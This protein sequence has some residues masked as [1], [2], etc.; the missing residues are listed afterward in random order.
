M[1]LGVENFSRDL[2]PAI[3]NWDPSGDDINLYPTF[4]S[5]MFSSN[6]ADQVRPVM[7][8]GHGDAPVD[9]VPMGRIVLVEADFTRLTLLQLAKV[10][11]GSSGDS[12]TLLVPN[13]AGCAVYDLAKQI[14]IKP[15]CDGN[16]IS[17]D[18]DEWTYVFKAYPF[19]A[20]ELNYN[21]DDQR[22]VHITFKAYPDN[23]SGN[24]GNL[25]R[26]GPA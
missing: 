16:V 15:L 21:K 3:I 25:Y 24:V 6:T 10:I 7:E 8:D 18:T 26:F 13:K 5:I 12:N 1:A 11:H 20:I 2:G 14:I 22:V 17:A 4:G 19:E 23:T 9:D